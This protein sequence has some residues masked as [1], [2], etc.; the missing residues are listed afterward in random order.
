MEKRGWATNRPISK[1][2]TFTEWL[3][4]DMQG[5]ALIRT[6]LWMFSRGFPSVYTAGKATM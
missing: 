2:R 3:E 5:W 4:T 6:R 1:F